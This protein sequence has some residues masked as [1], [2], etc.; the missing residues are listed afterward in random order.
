M[1]AN[2]PYR[3]SVDAESVILAVVASEA[4]IWNTV[5]G[6]TAALLPGAVLRLPVVRAVPARQPAVGASELGSAVVQTCRTAAGALLGPDLA[7]LWLVPAVARCYLA[8][9]AVV[10][11]AD[12]VVP[13]RFVARVYWTDPAAAVAVHPAACW[14]AAVVVFWSR[15]EVVFPV[16][17]AP[18][19]VAVGQFL[20]DCLDSAVQAWPAAPV[21]PV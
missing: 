13:W 17:A 5:A 1:P 12:L 18:W 7:A 19:L 16:P 6:V 14:L 10:V 20:R 3:K 8:V 15:P 2:V 11:S 4:V 9:A 21:S